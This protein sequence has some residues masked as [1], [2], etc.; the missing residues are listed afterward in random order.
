MFEKGKAS[1]NGPVE[2]TEYCRYCNETASTGVYLP[3]AE[4]STVSVSKAATCTEDGYAG[5]ECTVCGHREVTAI[6]APG[7]SY[8][9]GTCSVCGEKEPV[10]TPEYIPGDLTGDGTVNAMD[11]NIT[12]RIL[13]G[14]VTPTEIQTL[15]GDINGDGLFNGKDANYLARVASGAIS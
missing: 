8:K 2:I 13:S 4:H 6:T 5:T 3:A 15:A 1:C 11:V 9:N 14:A 7:H 12:K 10:V